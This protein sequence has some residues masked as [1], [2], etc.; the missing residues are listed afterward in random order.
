VD[1]TS[2]WD[3][4]EKSASGGAVNAGG[5]RVVNC[6]GYG[7][8]TFGDPN[9][10]VRHAVIDALH[11]HA[12][13]SRMFPTLEL[14]AADKA[15]NDLLPEHLM[16]CAFFSTGSE[17]V[18]AALRL[19]GA[20]GIDDLYALTGAF[21]G[22]TLGSLALNGSPRQRAYARNWLP[23]VRFIEFNDVGALESLETELHE[24]SAVFVEPVQGEAGV[25]IADPEFWQIL[26]HV[27][28]QSGALLVV[29]EVQTGLG[30]TGTLWCH[31]QLGLHADVL[32]A[33]KA[34]GG[35][36]IPVSAVAARERLRARYLADP[37]QSSSTFGGYPVAAVAV[38][39][40]TEVVLGQDVGRLAEQRGA[41]LQGALD[42]AISQSDGC[43]TAVRRSGLMIGIEHSN[44]RL[45]RTFSTQL[46]ASGVVP[47]LSMSNPNVIRLLPSVFSTELDIAEI[48]AALDAAS[49]ALVATSN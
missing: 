26:Q 41:E 33:G 20:N 12:F 45:A 16:Q 47:S 8:C 42:R 15:M 36:C 14:R 44:P 35:G 23:P 19:C 30:R 46:V 21:H 22:R 3:A 10:E 9:P 49:S 7:V 5:R 11:G 6:G 24:R 1:P 34:L 48:G 13:G 18:E 4:V 29:D 2:A 28:S 39:A 40:T 25:R 37:S 27:V 43:I 31:E 38:R 32:I 17:A